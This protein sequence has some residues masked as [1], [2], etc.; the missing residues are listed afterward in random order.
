MQARARSFTSR[1]HHL[2][3]HQPKHARNTST[4]SH[5]ETHRH[6]HCI[7]ENSMIEVFYIRLNRKH[8]SFICDMLSSFQD[9]HN[10]TSISLYNQFFFF[11]LQ[12]VFFSHF[13]RKSTNIN[14]GCIWGSS[15]FAYGI[16]LF[17]SMYGTES[18][19]MD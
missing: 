18:N 4:H 19:I 3:S 8:F 2:S 17:I 12:F 10:L 7:R 5:T 14:S 1:S 16:H 9:S 6:A 11:F 15:I 13:N